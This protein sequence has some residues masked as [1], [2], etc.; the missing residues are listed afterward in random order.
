MVQRTSASGIS[1]MGRPTQ[2]VK[3]MNIKD[4]DRISAVALVVESGEPAPTN[5]D[6][7]VQDELG[8]VEGQDGSGG[9]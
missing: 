7:P 2:G 4:D 1:T 9:A 8:E 6:T 5:G 3:V